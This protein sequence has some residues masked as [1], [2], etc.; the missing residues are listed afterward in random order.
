MRKISFI[1][2]ALALVLGVTQ[3][4][5]ENKPLASGETQR[6]VLTANNG[7]D[8]S[9]V[10]VGATATMLNL[11][12]ESTDVIMAS[13]AV[14][15]PLSYKTGVGSDIAT[16]EGSVTRKEGDQV[17]F[18]VGAAPASF[19]NQS[20][21][22]EWIKGHMHLEGTADYNEEGVYGEDEEV[23]MELQYAVLKLDLSALGT[24]DGTVVTITNAS[25]T[26]ATVAGV[27]T[28]TKVY[29]VA[30]P[31]AAS[32]TYTF[33]SE[34]GTKTMENA[35]T[36]ENNI[37]YTKNDS[38]D[39]ILVEPAAPT[40][41]EGALSGM[42][43]VSD[44]KQVWFSQGNLQYVMASQ[45]WRFA[46]NQYDVVEQN[47][48]HNEN[49]SGENVVSLF[50][51]G[52]SGWNNG[53]IYYQPYDTHYLGEDE[54]DPDFPENPY[55]N[56]GLGYGPKNGGNC[57]V[58]LT[59]NF[60]N[61]DW[62][63][64]NAITN[65]GAEA[66][67]WRTLSLDEWEYLIDEYGEHEVRKG[68]WKNNVSVNGVRGFVIAPDDWNL[69]LQDSYGE[70]SSPMTWKQA[71]EAGLVFLPAAGCRHG[72]YVMDVK[73]TGYYWSSTTDSDS[74]AAH[75]FYFTDGVINPAGTYCRPYGAAVRL[76]SEVK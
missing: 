34:V 17:V 51:W 35:W 37:F 66:G 59:G 14:E 69:A 63:V 8:G 54:W 53:N 2:A 20:G 64:Y 28:A 31:A 60:A 46:T 62:G 10:A 58:S 23:E 72:T 11:T 75:E 44:D 57:N 4:K 16:F 71:E 43:S 12:W 9:K 70:S 36:L 56:Q 52:T 25:G 33:S 68:K 21:N 1:M 3:C 6:I 39:A 73:A 76:V 40:A 19:E 24:E 45:T 50:G 55:W 7:N 15:G 67:K 47:G 18:T 26:V 27:K 42:F 22:V 48:S 74:Y 5:K 38:G 13:G 32:T 61:A 41:P 49:Y 30:M 65:G 29:Y